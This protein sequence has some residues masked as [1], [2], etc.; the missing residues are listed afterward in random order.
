MSLIGGT[1]LTYA[2]AFVG[3]HTH[4]LGLFLEPDLT[5]LNLANPRDQMA[6]GVPHSR[7]PEWFR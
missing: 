3:H 2:S 5:R 4:H 6:D 7:W 1:A